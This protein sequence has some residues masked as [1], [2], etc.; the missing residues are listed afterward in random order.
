MGGGMWNFTP[1]SSRSSMMAGFTTSMYVDDADMPD[2]K[3]AARPTPEDVLAIGHTFMSEKFPLDA[4][5]T[6]IAEWKSVRKF[7]TGD[8]YTLLPITADTH[9]WCAVQFH[10]PDPAAGIA[11]VFRRHKSPL[12]QM[13]LGLREIDPAANYSV[14]I[15]PDHDEAPRERM[16]GR[17]LAE[18]VITI[19]EKPGS[20]LIRYEKI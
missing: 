3:S 8:M 18:L 15:S 11:L 16:T 19:P 9:D 14:S 4:A 1:Y 2:E 17:Q 20:L 13:Q 10:R 12:T 7:F 5:K 6:A